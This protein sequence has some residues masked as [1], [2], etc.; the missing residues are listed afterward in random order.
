[1]PKLKS[2]EIK[3]VQD[4]LLVWFEKNQ[5]P[6][7]W[8]E[9]YEPYQVWISEIMLQQTQVKTVLPYFDRWMKALPTIQ[10]VAEAKEDQVLKLWEGLGYYSRARNIQKAAKQIMEQHGGEFPHVYDDILALPGVGKYTA[11]AISSIAFNQDRSI[12]DGNV[13]RV[14]SRLFLYTKNTRTPEAEKKMWQWAKEVLPIGKARYFNQAMME[15]GA[16][17]C[18]PSGPD[19]SVCPLNS[20]C[21]AHKKGMVDKI[22]DR[23][24]AKVS[25]NIKV[26]IAVIKKD[27]KVFIQ[28]RPAKGL[29]GGLWEFPG[30][31]VEKGESAGSAL[32]R[33]LVEETGLKVKNVR[34]IKR[35]KHAYTS[36][37][38]DLHCFEADYDSGKVRLEA[39]TAGKW[40][41]VS[42]LKE[43]PF[44]AANVELIASLLEE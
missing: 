30:G 27:G 23:G 16:L 18:T 17:T 21:Q 14:L 40:V 43:Y 10:S 24:P 1:M 13:V 39:A 33:E 29:M 3:E 8:R 37:K 7:P 28:K 36:F 31:K 6:L 26:A 25:K 34:I 9:K 15:F 32:H 11:G 35:I 38:V 4:K 42:D 12:V 5:R 2:S 22:P 20:V 41:K 44:P 19:C